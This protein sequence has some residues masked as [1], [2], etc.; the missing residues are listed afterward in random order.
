[1]CLRSLPISLLC[2]VFALPGATR[3]SGAAC[4]TAKFQGRTLDYELVVTEGHPV[5]AQ[6]EAEARLRAKGYGDYYKHLDIIRP[7]NLTNLEH[8]YAVVIRSEFDDSRGKPRSV[9]GCG[10]SA[11]SYDDA[12][13]DAL[14]DAQA[15]FWGWKPDRDGYEVVSKQRY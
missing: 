15:Y 11:K 1:M 5:E 13:W 7:Q 4:V 10:F 2:L 12:L 9:V 14:H 3:A 6:E 8:A